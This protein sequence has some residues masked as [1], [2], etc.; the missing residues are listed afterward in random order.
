VPLLPPTQ[1]SRA[2]MAEPILISIEGNIGSG[3][4]TL[5]QALQARNPDWHY[6]Q[7][8]VDSWMGMKDDAGESLLSKF[9]RDKRRWSYTFQNTA[10]LTR[11]L[12]IQD[13]V[14]RW[15][16]GGRKG[17]PVFVTE[18]CVQ[19]DANV[20]AK[21]LRDDGEIDGLEWMLY[22]QWYKVFGSQALAPA[23]YIHVDTPVTVCHERIARRARPG[24]VGGASLIPIEYLDKLDTAHFRWLRAYEMRE[25]VLRYDNASKD[26]TPLESVE[27]FIRARVGAPPK[28]PRSV[29][30]L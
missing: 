16:E 7:E 27:E 14:Q 17:S 3:K 19:T 30:L 1:P 28:D 8:P 5:F 11:I 2:Q 24:E 21:L 15:K 4:S 12:S 18:R 10:L 20:F 23:A 9:Y 6:I 25:P 29:L 13:K 22:Q 26:P